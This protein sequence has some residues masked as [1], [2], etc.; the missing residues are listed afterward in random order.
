MRSLIL[1]LAALL[2]FGIAAQAQTRGNGQARPAEQG[3]AVAD[4]GG[5]V[6]YSDTLA[7]DTAAVFP[8]AKAAGDDGG[9][10]RD[11]R[12]ERL[13]DNVNTPFGLIA[14]LASIGAGGIV[15]AV[16]FVLL[17]LLVVFSPVILI[18]AIF[19]LALKRKSERYRIIEKAMETGQP[20]PDVL[21]RSEAVDG[22]RYWR[23]GVLTFSIGLGLM[24]FALC[25]GAP[26]FAGIGLFVGIYGV[27]QAVIGRTSARKEGGEEAEDSGNL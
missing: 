18:V 25:V 8:A 19:Y 22:D 16:F 23:R 10:S 1:T 21:G 14:Y 9:C 7:A 24:A 3:M 15:V 4:T 17:C 5:I 20:I 12:M 13:L 11:D 26:P 2:A 27:G 6:A